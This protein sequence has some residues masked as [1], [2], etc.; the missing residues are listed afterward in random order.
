[1]KRISEIPFVLSSVRDVCS[2]TSSSTT[3]AIGDCR[4]LFEILMGLSEAVRVVVSSVSATN[5]LSSSL[6]RIDLR[7]SVWLVTLRLAGF[8]LVLQAAISL[9]ELT[10][11]VLVL[12]SSGLLGIVPS[13]EVRVR[14]TVSDISC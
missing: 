1:M 2:V 7:C 8:G 13:K 10:V 5:D 3:N 12:V 11:A 6:H 4:G 14:L 9:V